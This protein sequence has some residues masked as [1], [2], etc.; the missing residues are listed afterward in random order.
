MENSKKIINRIREENIRPLPK[1][2][3]RI[4]RSLTLLAFFAAILLGALAFSIIL[5][6]VQQTDFSVIQHLQHSKLELFL[7]LLPVFW[8]STL[9]LMLFLGTYSAFHA[10]KGYKFAWTQRAAVYMA[11]SILLGTLFF[12]TGGARL[13]EQAFAI[14]MHA[15]ESIQEKKLKIWMN[16]EAGFLSGTI[17]GIQDSVLSLRD[18]E[19][20][21]WRVRLHGAFIAPVLSLEKGEKVK[22]IGAI[23]NQRVFQA[24]EL[25]PWGGMELHQ[26]KK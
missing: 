21:S 4:K 23:E 16:P 7:G 8:L 1:A 24:K 11:F 18:F 3:F 14:R 19:N 25:R 22:M 12:I 6:A 5:F 2:I 15:Y 13:L 10:G 26:Q 17:E 9:A 20:Q